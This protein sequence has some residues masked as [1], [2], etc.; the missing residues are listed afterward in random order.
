MRCWF[1]C[2]SCLLLFVLVFVF[3]IGLVLEV[4]DERLE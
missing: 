3:S 1:R 4:R 2:S